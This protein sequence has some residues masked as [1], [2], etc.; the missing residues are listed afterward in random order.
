MLE[1]AEIPE[2]ARRLDDR[3]RKTVNIRQYNANRVHCL[4]YYRWA[5][6]E[7]DGCTS[8]LRVSLIWQRALKPAGYQSEAR[9]PR[10]FQIGRRFKL[11]KAFQIGEG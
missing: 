8:R 5:R 10:S 11:G 4:T 9:K 6:P 1:I 3:P 7:L 2:I